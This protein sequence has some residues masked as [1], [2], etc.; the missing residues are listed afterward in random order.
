MPVL[1]I[2]HLWGRYGRDRCYYSAQL[3]RLAIHCKT[4][5]DNPGKNFIKKLKFRSLRGGGLQKKLNSLLML[6]FWLNLVFICKI[7]RENRFCQYFC[8]FFSIFR[9]NLDFLL[10]KMIFSDLDL[11][12]QFEFEATIFELKQIQIMFWNPESISKE[13]TAL[14]F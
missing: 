5:G 12:T 13:T 6:Q 11:F 2:W 9:Q 7:G 4:P 3:I 1:W 10:K 8:T 14:N